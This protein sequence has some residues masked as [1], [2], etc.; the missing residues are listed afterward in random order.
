MIP[1]GR[2]RCARPRLRRLPATLAPNPAPT[3]TPIIAPATAPTT[4]PTPHFPPP[5]PPL[6][7]VWLRGRLLLASTPRSPLPRD[8]WTA[9]VVTVAEASLSVT[10]GGET[11]VSGLTL[12]G[13]GSSGGG[14]TAGSSGGE[15]L[16]ADSWRLSFE[17]GK[18][19]GERW[20]MTP[21]LKSGLLLPLAVSPISLR[22][23]GAQ[24]VPSVS[25]LSFTYFTPPTFSSVEPMQG[26]TSAATAVTLRG[27][28]LFNSGLVRPVCVLSQG[29]VAVEVVANVTY[30]AS[31]LRSNA[32]NATAA[33]PNATDATATNGTEV[34]SGPSPS[35]T[36]ASAASPPLSPPPPESLTCLIDASWSAGAV[37]IQL[38][39]TAAAGNVPAGAPAAFY[40]YTEPTF[41]VDVRIV[42]PLSGLE[43]TDVTVTGECPAPLRYCYPPPP[44]QSHLVLAVLHLPLRR[45]SQGLA[46]RLGNILFFFTLLYF[47]SLYCTSFP[48][49]FGFAA[50]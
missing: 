38:R 5:T 3:P 22:L 2:S 45:R 40:K 17:A 14:E 26:P 19:S 37:A 8:Q 16:P 43:G 31:T 24:S 29:S 47:T 49:I 13:W 1:S 41:A 42:V 30:G 6:T 9:L 50:G 39:T 18:A 11:L 20:L 21:N 36:D 34:S 48:R 28:H 23:H 27:S 35:A 44:P 32:T 46:S 10:V 4:A 25:N 33:A 15:T 12:P 7:Q